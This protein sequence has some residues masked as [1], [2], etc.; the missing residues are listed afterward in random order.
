[1]ERDSD[2][3]SHPISFPVSTPADIR[4]MF[5]PISYSKGASIIRMINGYLGDDAFK[6]ALTAY[7]R[8]F[9]Y[10]NAVQV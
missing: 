8:K 7:L 1:M 2:S 9:E 5:D 6:A 4:R 3:S 10:S